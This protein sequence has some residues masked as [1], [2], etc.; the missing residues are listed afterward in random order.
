MFKK[1]IIFTF[2][3]LG[4]VLTIN[5][6]WAE[7]LVIS[8]NGAGSDNNI[9]ISKP[10][11]T[12]VS[13]DS[14]ANVNN[15]TQ[16]TANSGGN[17]A[18]DNNGDASI[19]TGDVTVEEKLKTEANQSI[20]D[21]PC[22]PTP[23]TATISGNGAD[24]ENNIDIQSNSETNIDVNQSAT[25]NNSSQGV[26][27]SGNN[28]ASDNN[29]SVS[30]ETGNVNVE[31]ETIN[32]GINF[33]SVQ[34]PQGSSGETKLK[35]SG[36]GA[37]SSNSISLTDNQSTSISVDNNAEI[38]NTIEW[39]VI[40]GNNIAEG[41]LGDVL[42]R[43]GDANLNILLE[44]GPINISEVII[45]CC[46]EAIITPAQQPPQGG[47]PENPPSPTG[48]QQPPSVPSA[49]SP[50]SS[51]SQA[52]QAAGAAAQEVLGI[53]G[54]VLPISGSFW[55]VILTLISSILFFLGLYLRLHPGRDPSIRR[56]RFN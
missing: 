56:I 27:S 23:I 30:I 50:T 7:D 25:V 54:E 29:G 35:I 31:Q 49:P 10:T 6:A 11:T 3:S 2:V 45:N 16:T 47:N 21:I 5:N 20:V 12:E 48:E 4:Y 37:D 13:Q 1:I 40:T 52:A 51:I 33:S 18:S 8:D 55:I 46:E 9:A 28:N 53:A 26:A 41:N 42:I 34:V 32:K 15:D 39:E 44:N 24:S 38:E 14:S 19:Q 17:T 43:T 36:N 22:C